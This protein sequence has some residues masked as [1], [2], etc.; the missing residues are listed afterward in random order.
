MAPSFTLRILMV[1][2]QDGIVRVQFLGYRGLRG[3]LG[4]FLLA[5][6]ATIL[7][8]MPLNG[9]HYK[10]SILL[11]TAADIAITVVAAVNFSGPRFITAGSWTGSNFRCRIRNL[12]KD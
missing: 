12:H 4:R 9:T 8:L 5:G 6:G 2:D 11:L 1:S 7:S 3:G 10:V